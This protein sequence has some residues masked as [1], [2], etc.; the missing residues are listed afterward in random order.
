MSLSLIELLTTAPSKRLR[1][2]I[3][4]NVH[5]IKKRSEIFYN[6]T[7]AEA[8]SILERCVAKR[9]LEDKEIED[10]KSHLC[11]LLQGMETTV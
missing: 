11:V 9:F 3:Q 10:T 6:L 5:K 2:D 7:D 1:K 8:T 4:C